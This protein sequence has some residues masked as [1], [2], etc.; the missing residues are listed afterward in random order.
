MKRR[1][2]QK[3]REAAQTSPET[4]ND[5]N[6]QQQQQQPDLTELSKDL[7]SGWQVLNFW[8]KSFIYICVLFCAS[9]AVYLYPQK[10]CNKFVF[11]PF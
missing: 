2:A 7:P 3:A 9:K 1:R 4:R 10:K 5:E 8:C 6:Q 11:G